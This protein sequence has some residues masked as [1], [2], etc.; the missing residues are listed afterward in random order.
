[1]STVVKQLKQ[2]QAD[3]H[4]LYVKMHNYHWNIKGM[5]FFPVHN[6]TEEIYN[7]MSELYDDTAE[8]VL[9]LGEKPY[10]T[11]T[12]LAKATKIKEETKD[13]FKSK[14][15]VAAI[16]KEYNYLLK[17]F[18]KLSKSAADAGDKTTEAFADEKVAKLE[19]ELW[20]LGNMTK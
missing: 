10:L 4:A 18:A 15:V 12:E 8:R 19:K 11:M 14:E 20:M 3:A 6:H 7:S 2:I 17:A 1:M 5:D 13:S 16:I 9:Q